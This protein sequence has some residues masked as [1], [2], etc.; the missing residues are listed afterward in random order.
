MSKI[1]R[2]IFKK[3]S[4]FVGNLLDSLFLTNFSRKGLDYYHGY[5][6]N[7]YKFN[8]EKFCLIHVPRTGG[9]TLNTYLA[10]NKKIHL[11]NNG[12]QHFPVSFLCNPKDYKYITCIRNPIDRTISHYNMALEMKTKV[13]SFGFSKWLINEKLSRNLFCQYFSGHVYEDVN[14]RIYN[15]ALENLKKFY[16]VVNFDNFENDTKTLLKIL[17]VEYGDSI[18]NYGY[19]IQK[20]Y[21]EDLDTMKKISKEYNYWDTKLYNEFLNFKNE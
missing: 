1:K 9:G 15:I 6:E 3:I 19:I 20:K 21:I 4:P 2:K 7:D 12:A 10:N 11:L 13:A 16:F 5:H 14:D 8:K 17:N 18:K